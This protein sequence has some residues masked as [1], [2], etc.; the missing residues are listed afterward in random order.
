LALCRSCFQASAF[1]EKEYHAVVAQ[2]GK[3]PGSLLKREN[4]LRALLFK[5]FLPVAAIIG[6]VN[7]FY[8]LCI[9]VGFN[10]IRPE[11]LF[12]GSSHTANIIFKVSLIA[13]ALGYF[14][15]RPNP[16]SLTSCGEFWLLLWIWLATVISLLFSKYPL[17][18]KAWY[19]SNEIL[20]LMGLGCLILGIVYRK[21][22]LIKFQ[23]FILA[24]IS[25][26]SLWGIEQ[27]F[28]G[29]ERLEG[30]GGTAFGDTNGVAAIGVLYFPIAL[31]SFLTTKEK[32]RK[33][34]WLVSA[35][36][37]AG[38]IIFTQSRGGFLGL[39]VSVAYLALR[40]KKKKSLLIV[41]CLATFAASPF[42]A[43]EYTERLSTITADE[44]ERDMSSGSR[45]VLWQAGLLMFIDHPIF[46]V[47]LLNFAK[48]KAPYKQYLVGKVDE[49]L[50]D[51]S[52]QGFKVGHG[53][54]FT[55]LMAEGGLLLTIPYLWLIGGFLV[56]A[57]QIKK[58]KGNDGDS[59][60]LDLLAG[61]E[62]GVVGHCFSIMFIN[63][64]FMYFLPIQLV[65]GRQIIRALKEE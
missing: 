5:L 36:L 56:G 18:R 65:I 63:A 40:T 58:R 29:N 39:V 54:F 62:A 3:Y 20:I 57:L 7:P 16:R 32:K 59:E 28:R 14:R 13:T 24:C 53:T 42:L 10:I 45:L 8:G 61:M 27:H 23:N 11:M 34:I 44:E 6:F 19:Y 31:N 26:M 50:L 38:L 22:Q 55:Q 49:E 17:E 52:F 30:L 1:C 51:Y 64:L 60:L 41:C 21:E 12:W 33:I 4:P 9:Y 47:G 37:I 43:K 48:A 15:L 35:L 25:F 46:G 2:T